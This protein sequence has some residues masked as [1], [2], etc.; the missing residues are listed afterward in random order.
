MP[1]MQE[2]LVSYAVKI[3][4]SGMTRPNGSETN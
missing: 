3:N 1:S 2:M 4:E